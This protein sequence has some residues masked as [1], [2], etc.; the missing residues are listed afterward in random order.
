MEGEMDFPSAL[1]SLKF[2]RRVARA[3]WNGK[4]MYIYLNLGSFDHELLGFAASDQPGH[5][6]PSTIDGISIG[7]FQAGDQGTT[8]RLPNINMRTATGATVTGWLA[9]QADMLAEDWAIVHEPQA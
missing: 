3:G 6:H 2:G 7:L 8:T 5:G 4:G 9:S 1:T